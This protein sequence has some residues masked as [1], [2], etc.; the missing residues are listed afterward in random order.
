MA[1]VSNVAFTWK[2]APDLQNRKQ[3]G[4]EDQQAEAAIDGPAYLAVIKLLGTVG[5]VDK[6]QGNVGKQVGDANETE[7]PGL[8]KAVAG[9]VNTACEKHQAVW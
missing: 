9:A 5:D 2:T 6:L 4:P 7:E 3:S 1:R 8:E